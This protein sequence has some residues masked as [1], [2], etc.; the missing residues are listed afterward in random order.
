MGGALSGY[1]AL[2]LTD[3][4]GMLCSR[5]LADMGAEVIRVEKPEKS[6]D[7]TLHAAGRHSP[8]FCYLNLGKRSITLNLELESGRK[9]FQ[10]LAKTADF[11]IESH[12]PDYLESLGLGYSDLS[13]INPGVIMTSITGFGQTGPYRDYKFCDL[14]TAALGGQMYVCGEPGMPPLKL[15]GNQTYYAAGLF[16]A[17]GTLLAL[18]ARHRTGLGQHVDIAIMECAAAT[19]DHVL[20]RYF[21]QGIIARRQGSLYWNNAFRIFPCRDGYILLTL[22][23]QWETMVELLAAE[24]MADDLAAEKWQNRAERLKNIDHVIAV[25]ERWTKQHTVAELVELGQLMRFPWAA[26]TSIAGLRDSPQLKERGFFREV[27][28]SESGEKGLCPGAP[29]KCRNS[30]WQV[31]DRPPKRGEH[32]QA[33]YQNE[34]GLSSAEIGR[35]MRTGVI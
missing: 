32:N 17:I 2:D 18:Q 15:F 20:V 31:G 35:L 12:S 28:C 26:V 7:L 33:V 30:P 19:L 5:L 11:I 25:L 1:R 4:K 8:A 14:V 34:L 10:R 24:G 3:E 13:K 6:V 9:I 21:Y 29:V 27:A 22:F 23:Q 16:A